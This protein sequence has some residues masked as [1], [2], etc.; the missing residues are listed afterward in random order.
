MQGETSENR[1]AGNEETSVG[2]HTKNDTV[3]IDDG[4]SDGEHS[5]ED[6]IYVGNLR[7][8]RFQNDCFSNTAVHNLANSPEFRDYIMNLSSQLLENKPVSK[9]L[10]KIFGKMRTN[11]HVTDPELTDTFELRSKFD[12]R[13]DGQQHDAFEYIL[14]ILNKTVTEEDR[15][16]GNKLKANKDGNTDENDVYEQAV[17]GSSILKLFTWLTEEKFHCENEN[18]ETPD[19]S[20]FDANYPCLKVPITKFK[21]VGGVRVA[22]LV[23]CISD[24]F[25]NPYD[26]KNVRK[27]ANSKCNTEIKTNSKVIIK[28]APPIA[29]VQILRA[30]REGKKNNVPIETTE[31][32]TFGKESFKIKCITNHLGK[33]TYSG[34]YNS[35]IRRGKDWIFANDD[36]VRQASA[37]DRQDY[38][39]HVYGMLYLKQNASS[40]GME[41]EREPVSTNAG[42]VLDREA[43]PS[44]AGIY[45]KGTKFYI[46][47]IILIKSNQICYRKLSGCNSRQS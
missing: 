11:I 24:S 4:D 33:T 27:C 12:E 39:Q 22:D 10:N 1:T 28:R 19:F 7:N 25:Q 2:T 38:L 8:D 13:N 29:L 46:I 6:Q 47:I 31:D 30:P 5:Q 44:T 26:P 34:H 15:E 36:T 35:F 17:R 16:D 32:I 37:Y 3:I 42:S 18:C 14:E 21:F 41:S 45:S 43:G 9:I 20:I 23:G 40:L